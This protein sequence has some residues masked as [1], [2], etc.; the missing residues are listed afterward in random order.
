M[1]NNP[2]YLESYQNLQNVKNLCVERWHFRMLNNQF[3]NSGYQRAIKSKI[4]AGYTN[5]L[6]IGT[7]TGILSIYAHQAGGKTI[8]ACDSSE[9]MINLADHILK[10][11]KMENVKLI[12][13]LSN[14]L[15]CGEDLPEKVSMIVTEILDCGIFG[16]GILQTLIH[17]K[18]NLLQSDG[19]IIPNSVQIIIFGLSSKI[20]ALGN[21]NQ[22]E[23]FS[24]YLYLNNRSLVAKRNEPYDAED[25]SLVKDFDKMTSNAQALSLNFNNLDELKKLY[26]GET[27]SRIKLK[28]L[29]NGA[30]DA[31]A[32]YFVVN[33]DQSDNE[34]IN[35]SPF[36]KSCWEQA[37]F[38]L[39]RRLF[40]QKDKE[41]SLLMSC[42]DGKLTL[43]H[44]YNALKDKVF[45]I[46]EEQLKFINDSEYLNKLEFEI[47]NSIKKRTK[48]KL[49]NILDFS[50]FPYV[51]LI[52]LKEKRAEK[53]FAP[54]SCSELI[55]F[56]CENNCMDFNQIILLKSPIDVLVNLKDELLDLV[57][58]S[59]IEQLGDLRAG[60]I[61]ESMIIKTK[62]TPNGIFVPQKI[63]MCGELV[64]SDWLLNVTSVKNPELIDLGI[65]CLNCYETENQLGIGHFEYVKMSNPVNIGEIYFDDEFHENSIQ[66]NLLRRDKEVHGLLYYYKIQFV[67]GG[68]II[69][70][71]RYYSHLKR[72]AFILRPSLEVGRSS[73][74]IN[75][76]QKN[77]V[78]RCSL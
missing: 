73:I 10:K 65:S 64:H 43:E 78:F 44:N 46:D 13:K 63:K 29:K 60:H 30:L 28:N 59:P 38:K 7:G 32:V 33:L 21:T 6:D 36:S 67:H 48:K 41:L 77:N 20:I 12:N 25:L 11:N 37:I 1:K 3:R 72:A 53:L 61:S 14:D 42:K 34:T 24:D 70:T 40:V 58:M 52:L 27:K 66:A 31:F 9:T 69:S 71:N 75:L 8:T 39:N 17:A 4:N 54:E 50:Y 68:E 26:S 5:I 16:E 76:A 18:E 55:K 22:N 23:S 19:Q 57:I 74:S 56:I 62:L 2:N 51:G 45:P 15:V 35:S 49:G 47:Y